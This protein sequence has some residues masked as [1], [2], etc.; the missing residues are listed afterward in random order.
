MPSRRC[1]AHAGCRA[2]TMPVHRRRPGGQRRAPASR[3]LQV[4]LRAAPLGRLCRGRSGRRECGRGQPGRRRRSSAADGHS[5]HWPL[6]H[7]R[8]PARR[9]LC[10]VHP[11][12][13]PQCAPPCRRDRPCRRARALL[14]R[15][16][17]RPR[18]LRP[19]GGDKGHAVDIGPIGTYQLFT[20]G[21]VP[22]A[23]MFNQPD[24][25]RAPFWLYF[26]VAGIDAGA[27]P[28]GGRRPGPERPPAGAWW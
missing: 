9:R 14:G 8:Q 3:H 23:G 2:P 15:L 12:G 26:D 19:F 6:R 10:A 7:G 16:A 27:A 11:A 13:P 17:K 5:G 21:D 24:G 25:H 18:L 4:V 20:T 22:I 28:Q 1:S